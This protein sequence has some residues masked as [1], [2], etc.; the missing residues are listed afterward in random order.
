MPSTATRARA[1][2]RAAAV[3]SAVLS[4]VATATDSAIAAVPPPPPGATPVTVQAGQTTPDIN[5]TLQPLDSFGTIAGKLADVKSGTGTTLY[6]VTPNGRRVNHQLIGSSAE[7]GRFQLTAPPSAR[8][9]A[10]CALHPNR[11]WARPTPYPQCAGGVVWNGKAPPATAN[12]ISL[13]AGQTVHLGTVALKPG[14]KIFGQVTRTNGQQLQGNVVAQSLSHPNLPRVIAQVG[15]YPHPGY[16][17]DGLAPSPKGWIVCVD[18]HT[19]YTGRRKFSATGSVGTCAGGAIWEGGPLPSDA[20]P[21]HVAPGAKL[22]HISERLPD[23]GEI[24]GTV[25]AHGSRRT[26]R[27]TFVAVFDH[28]GHELSDSYSA[29][30]YRVDGLS[31]GR[32]YVC[33]AA[34]FDD[35][36]DQGKHSYFGHCYHGRQWAPGQQPSGDLVSVTRGAVTSG[37]DPV[38]SRAATIKGAVS[39]AKHARVYLYDSTGKQIETRLANPSGLYS[40]LWLSP[41]SDD[42]YY[43][44]AIDGAGVLH[45]A[46]G[47]PNCYGAT[48]WEGAGA[49]VPAGAQPVQVRAGKTTTGID[50]TLPAGGAISGTVTAARVDNDWPDTLVYL[51]DQNG[52]PIQSTHVSGLDGS[53]EFEGVAAG[54]SH[55]VCVAGTS[56]WQGPDKGGR[57]YPGRCYTAAAWDG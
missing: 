47:A 20:E 31:G 41:A 8:G 46:V 13:S 50:F 53:Y 22:H 15:R 42:G 19:A 48:S 51:F 11:H 56:M 29:A 54:T 18:G 25:V 2:L 1:R 32:Y 34:R 9:Y 44:C 39:G 4:L 7:N 52:T 55:R 16:L 45:D 3:V 40:F 12:F 43:V 33:A 36:D 10:L 26:L 6:L 35:N 5:V 30:R 21:I 23:A 57:K 27:G 17:L 49:R 38:L 24:A 37:V 14:S 28:D